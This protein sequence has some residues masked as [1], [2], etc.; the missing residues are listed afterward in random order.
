[1]KQKLQD[2]M[3]RDVD[4]Q[5]S[6]MIRPRKKIEKQLGK[7]TKAKIDPTSRLTNKIQKNFVNLEKKTNLQTR[8]LF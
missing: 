6:L 4:S 3:I 5:L 8:H 1:M 2:K 7:A